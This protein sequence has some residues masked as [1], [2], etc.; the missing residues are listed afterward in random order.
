[1]WIGLILCFDCC[2][3]RVGWVGILVVY[4]CLWLLCGCYLLC[5]LMVAVLLFLASRFGFGVLAFL[6]LLRRRCLLVCV[7]DLW[8]VLCLVLG[9][10]GG[11]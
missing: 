11:L 5:W 4:F 7:G 8:L 1:M 2:F 6:V 9:A 10:A 3:L